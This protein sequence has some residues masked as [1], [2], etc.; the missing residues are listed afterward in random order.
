MARPTIA[1]LCIILFLASWNNY[2]WPLLVSSQQEMMTAPVALGSL[3]GVN[4][5]S[6]GAVMTGAVLMTA[7]MLLVFIFLQ[8]WFMSGI[9]AGAVK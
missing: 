6:W 1:A 7:P 9:T 4:R 8:R 3:I 5:V 2:L